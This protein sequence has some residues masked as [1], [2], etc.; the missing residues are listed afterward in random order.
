MGTYYLTVF[1]QSGEK[2]L[3]TQFDASTH[4]EAKEIGKEKLD[5]EG[6][7][8]HTHRCVSPNAKLVLFHR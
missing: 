2:L 1:S 8:E 5:K 7:A 3:D 4:A 6:Y